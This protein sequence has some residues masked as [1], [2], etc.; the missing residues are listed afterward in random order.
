MGHYIHIN[1]SNNQVLAMRN[2]MWD[3]S[4]FCEEHDISLA[5]SSPASIKLRF[6][7]ESHTS[8]LIN[9]G[10]AIEL[11]LEHLAPDCLER[12]GVPQA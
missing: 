3:S 1:L 9:I 12:Q 5:R 6:F 7:Y 2:Q 10:H 4:L 11:D 8:A